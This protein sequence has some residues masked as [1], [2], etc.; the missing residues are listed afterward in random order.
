MFLHNVITAV[1]DPLVNVPNVSSS[2]SYRFCRETLSSNTIWLLLASVVAVERSADNRFLV[3]AQA[4]Q[5]VSSPA[6]CVVIDFNGIA[7]NYDKDSAMVSSSINSSSQG[8]EIVTFVT[9]ER[10]ER[11]LPASTDTDC[12]SC[13]SLLARLV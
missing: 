13:V 3:H 8:A 7:Q 11:F 1:H 9:K 4:G 6:S 10:Q 5:V 12:T 2:S